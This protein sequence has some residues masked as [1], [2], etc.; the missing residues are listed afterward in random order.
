MKKQYIALSL[1]VYPLIACIGIFA[2][3]LSMRHDS[4]LTLTK[5]IE[6]FVTYLPF[7]Y[8][9][10]ITCSSLGAWAA[11]GVAALAADVYA[12]RRFSWPIFIIAHLLT[13]SLFILPPLLLLTE[14]TPYCG[15]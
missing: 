14:V 13:A 1:I 2:V 8:Y 12:L 5:A 6:Y 7:V 15:S 11:V 4:L 9:H 3:V 10:G